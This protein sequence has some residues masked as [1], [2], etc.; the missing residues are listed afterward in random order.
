MV[1]LNRK[2]LSRIP[3]MENMRNMALAQQSREVDIRA[4]LDDLIGVFPVLL[5]A[6][7][8]WVVFSSVSLSI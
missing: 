7:W 1:H 5:T 4:S 3:G 8:S 6:C 2:I